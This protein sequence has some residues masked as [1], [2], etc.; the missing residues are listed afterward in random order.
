MNGMIKRVLGVLLALAVCLALVACTEA[1]PEDSAPVVLDNGNLLTTPAEQGTQ[2]ELTA[3]REALIKYTETEGLGDIDKME[4]YEN[5]VR[6]TASETVQ[7]KDNKKFYYAGDIKRL[8]NYPDG[9]ILDMPADWTPDFTLASAV[10]RFETDELTLVASNET[11]SLRDL[12]PA[13]DAADPAAALGEAYI[14]TMFRFITAPEYLQKNRVD[15]LSEE[16]TDLANGMHAYVLRM[17]LKGCAPTVQSYYTYVVIYNDLTLHQLIFKCVD[18]RDFSAVYTTFRTIYEKGAGVDGVTYPCKDNPSWSEETK[19]Y[20]DSLMNT[21]TIQ[22]GLFNGNIQD[23]PLEHRYPM[24][25]SLLDHKFPIVSSYTDQMQAPFPVEAANT[26]TADGRHVQYTVHFQYHWGNG[27]GESAPILDVYRGMLD[28][29]FRRFARQVVAYGEPLLFRVNN[30]MNSDWTCWAAINTMLDP[31]IFTQTWIRM[32]NIFEEE[33]ANAYCIWVWNPQSERSFPDT[34]WNDVQRYMPG[35]DYVDM[36]GLTAYNFGDGA[37]WNTFEQLYTALER[38]YS[39]DFG[40]WGWI[41]SEFG[42]SDTDEDKTR[43]A[44]WITDMFTCFEQGMYP[45]I[46]AAVWFNANDYADGKILNEIVL[47]DD[48]NKTSKAFREGLQRTQ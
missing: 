27:M 38:Y 47:T 17:H 11:A 6:T 46:K 12:E 40:D 29:D 44:Q 3:V 14:D 9:Y 33:G 42:C 20:Y 43:K 4:L 28:D 13:E 35:A 2:E 32:Y 39:E 15:K 31:D 18:D 25:E 48:P 22:W 26:I 16:T 5:G 30:E 21:E 7:V 45:N 23:D 19:A 36:L 37:D 8:V 34:N 24:M 10:S 1:P 41:I